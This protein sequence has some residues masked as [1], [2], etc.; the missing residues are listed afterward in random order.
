[1][2]LLNNDTRTHFNDLGLNKDFLNKTQKSMSYK[3]LKISKF[4]FIKIR[5]FS[6]KETV[7][8]MKR[9]T[10][11]RDSIGKTDIQKKDSYLE[12]TTEWLKGNR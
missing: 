6:S 7:R 9:Q 12:Y 2:K 3:I 8:E 1:M 4:D 10:Q 5:N 11:T